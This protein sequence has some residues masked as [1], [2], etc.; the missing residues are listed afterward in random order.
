M[1]R[2]TIE[3]PE[4]PEVLS[5]GSAPV[6]R[7]QGRLLFLFGEGAVPRALGLTADVL[8]GGEPVL[9]LDGGNCFDVYPIAGAA[10]RQRL[11][12]ESLLAR[13][14]VSRAFTCH[15]MTALAREGLGSGLRAYGARKAVVLG[16][17]RTYSNEDVPGYEACALLRGALEALWSAVREGHSILIAE[18]DLD[19]ERRAVLSPRM[20]AILGVMDRG[21]RTGRPA[22]TP[23]A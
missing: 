11:I 18:P 19:P 8:A 22:L 3:G 17:L 14:F 15:Q 12:P 5:S 4:K 7:Q 6:P 23:G 9:L 16:L 20:R 2:R 1:T 21:L 13:L 10:R